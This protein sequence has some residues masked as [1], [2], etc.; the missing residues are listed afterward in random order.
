MDCDWMCRNTNAYTG[1]QRHIRSMKE[2]VELQTHIRIMTEC[3]RI[4]THLSVMIEIAEMKMH[5][6]I[7]GYC[8]QGWKLTN[9]CD[10]Q[11]LGLVKH[12]VSSKGLL[13]GMYF[14]EKQ[15]VQNYLQARTVRKFR[16]VFSLAIIRFALSNWYGPSKLISNNSLCFNND[17]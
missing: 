5:M 10:S 3:A 9:C 16:P 15:C 4:R 8:L 1:Q 13:S 12:V 11:C 17:T 14:C 6:W 7:M 2:H